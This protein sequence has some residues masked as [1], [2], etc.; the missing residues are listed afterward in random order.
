MGDMDNDND[1]HYCCH[2]FNFDDDDD[3]DAYDC[4]NHYDVD[5]PQYVGQYLRP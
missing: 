1:Y 3:D 2:Y 4:D 5:V